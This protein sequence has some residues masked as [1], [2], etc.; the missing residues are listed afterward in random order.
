[1]IFSDFYGPPGIFANAMVPLQ[2]AIA[3]V[4]RARSEDVV[5]RRLEADSDYPAIEVWIELSSEEQLARHGRDLARA[6][7]AALRSDS[8]IDVWVL[9]RVVPLS[10]V[11]LNGEPRARGLG[12]V[13]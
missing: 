5:I 4:F 7:T 13:E 12:S 10:H 9:F 6:V 2:D 1:V 3:G 8:A 11:Y